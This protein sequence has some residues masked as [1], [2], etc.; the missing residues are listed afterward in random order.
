M[1]LPEG[2]SKIFIRLALSTYA[3]LISQIHPITKMVILQ[4]ERI[5]IYLFPNKGT[6]IIR[7]ASGMPNLFWIKGYQ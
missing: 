3:Q 7:S 5:L 2:M 1:I 4:I 6:A